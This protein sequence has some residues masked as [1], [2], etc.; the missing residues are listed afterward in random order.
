MATPAERAAKTFQSFIEGKK[1][2]I[3]DPGAAARAGLAKAL[4]ELGVKMHQIQLAKSYDEASRL[5][6]EHKPHLVLAEFELG[7]S[8]GLNLL[9]EQRS[10]HADAVKSLFVLVTSNTSQS[11]V[12]QAA[13][14]DVDT[15]VLKP[16]T[17]E[18]LRSAILSAAVAKLQPSEYSRAIE[19][20]KRLLFDGKPKEAM[21]LFEKARKLDSKP[22]LAFFY[23][24]QAQLMQKSLDGAE[25]DYQQGLNHNKIHYKCMVGLY[26]LLMEKRSFVEAYDV[27]KRISRY[28]PANPKRMTQVLRLAVMT[29]SYEDVERYYQ[30]FTGLDR[31][32][33]ELIKYICAALVVCGKHYLQT[34]F[35]SR[36]LSLF[37]KAATTGIGRA[38][39]LRE[40]IGALLA[41][42]LK[43]EAGE[44]L[45]KFPPEIRGGADY[46][47]M[48]YAIID[49]DADAAHAVDRGR[50]ILAKD[51]HDP[52]VYQILIHRSRQAGVD[53]NADQLAAEAGRRWPDQAASFSSGSHPL[54]KA[55][56]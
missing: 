25:G 51:I 23:H 7:K 6:H 37:E 46:L 55:R 2:L 32:D 5:I 17:L 8:S 38:N 12:A 40:V 45:A 14:E 31:R 48:E 24:G 22:A 36:A 56:K 20:G 34:G 4:N 29:K 33:E 11:A 41:Y 10:Q 18:V 27:V 1:V 42:E 26:E 49:A 39:L 52:L 28:F 47:A 30:V 9:Q 16:Y 21:E 35:Q 54:Q 50:K 15:F 19:E 43:K 44:F 13:E 53:E 3:A